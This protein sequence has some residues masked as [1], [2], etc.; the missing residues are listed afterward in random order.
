ML[1]AVYCGVSLSPGSKP[2]P[3]DHVKSSLTLRV[4]V[5][6]IGHV[7]G[8]SVGA[9]EFNPH[10]GG[11]KHRTHCVA[12]PFKA[13]QHAR[14]ATWGS[15]AGPRCLAPYGAVVCGFGRV[16]PQFLEGIA[17]ACFSHTRRSWRDRNSQSTSCL[18]LWAHR[19]RTA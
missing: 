10:W 2:F 9:G 6:C 4:C 12:H 11:S 18:V 8:S 16:A 17:S 14:Q 19:A 15:L 1:I 13:S 3:A 5:R 7:R